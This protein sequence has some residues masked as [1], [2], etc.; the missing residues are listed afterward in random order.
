MFFREIL[1]VSLETYLQFLIIGYLTFKEGRYS[2][3]GEVLGSLLGFFIIILSVFFLP[4]I[5]IYITVFS[6]EN[7]LTNNESKWN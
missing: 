6:T 2:S 3:I 1:G 4:S 5:L 7:Q